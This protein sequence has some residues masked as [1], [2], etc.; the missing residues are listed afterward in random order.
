MGKLPPDHILNDVS[1]VRDWKEEHD[2]DIWATDVAV[3]L[4]EQMAPEC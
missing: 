4:I 3:K 2:S 1:L